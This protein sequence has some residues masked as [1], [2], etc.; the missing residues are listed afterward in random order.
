MDAFN[1]QDLEAFEDTL[2]PDVEL[3]TMRGVRRGIQE[4]REWATKTPHGELEQRLVVDDAIEHHNHV[5]LLARRQWLWRED[6]HVAD[7]SETALLFTFRD[8]HVVRWQPF[9]DRADAFDAAGL[10]PPPAGAG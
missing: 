1:E 6:R 10:Q 9:R 8:G 2:H 7:E 3:Q 5:V 4:A